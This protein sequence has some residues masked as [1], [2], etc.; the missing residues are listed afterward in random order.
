MKTTQMYEMFQTLNIDIEQLISENNL[1]IKRKTYFKKLDF[2][3]MYNGQNKFK[4]ILTIKG[5]PGKLVYVQRSDNIGLFKAIKEYL[6]KAQERTKSKIIHLN[7]DSPK[8]KDNAKI[9]K[10][11]IVENKNGL[12]LKMVIDEKLSMTEAIDRRVRFIT[13]NKDTVSHDFEEGSISFSFM[14][15]TI[16]YLVNQDSILLSKIL[17]G[18]YNNLLEL[19]FEN[20]DDI[21]RLYKTKLSCEIR[22]KKWFIVDTQNKDLLIEKLKKTYFIQDKDYLVHGKYV[23]VFDYDDF[24]RKY[25]LDSDKL[26]RNFNDIIQIPDILELESDYDGNSRCII[27]HTNKIKPLT[28]A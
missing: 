10:E 24:A 8:L 3:R 7:S 16:R 9:I 17:N 19:L 26:V 27:T 1:D 13:V 15:R 11:K 12:S 5:F 6:P 25:I 22:A 23:I 4:E 18:D 14:N 28:A 21:T 2:S 20:I